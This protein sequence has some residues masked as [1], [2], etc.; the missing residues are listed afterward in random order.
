MSVSVVRCTFC[1]N[2][3]S[4]ILESIA[5]PLIAFN[6]YDYYCWYHRVDSYPRHEEEVGELALE[7]GFTHVSLSSKAMPMVK[8]VPRG[9]TGEG[10]VGNV[11][12][13]SCLVGCIDQHAYA[14]TQ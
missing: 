9:F 1:I 2:D 11:H 10:L 13:M 3:C 4:Q 8:I 14:V 6:K 12:C 7:M 5:L